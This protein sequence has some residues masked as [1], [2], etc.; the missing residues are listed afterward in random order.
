MSVVQGSDEWRRKGGGIG[1]C[2]L[3]QPPDASFAVQAGPGSP[4]PQATTIGASRVRPPPP[5]DRARRHRRGAQGAGRAGPGDIPEPCDP[6]HQ[7]AAQ[8]R[9]ECRGER[10][11]GGQ[12]SLGIGDEYLLPSIAAVVVGGTLITGG[13]GR[14]EDVT[15][16]T[17]NS[18]SRASV[19]SLRTVRYRW[20]R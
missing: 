3:S 16:K 15:K 4:S 1:G 14:V 2:L 5:A 13:R 7:P 19:H 6:V 8:H 11:H 9:A 10:A 12:A 20:T 17:L 18:D